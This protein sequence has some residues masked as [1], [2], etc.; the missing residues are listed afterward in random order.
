MAN[1]SAQDFLDVRL[2]M[3]TDFNIG[4]LIDMN[5]YL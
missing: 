1:T 5:N 4:I 3:A 2:F